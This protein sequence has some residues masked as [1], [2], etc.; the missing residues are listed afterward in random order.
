MNNVT[1]EL[2]SSRDQIIA[3]EN[4]R[5]FFDVIEATTINESHLHQLQEKIN[6]ACT[7]H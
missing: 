2:T 3:V 7:F 5:N 6:Q 1:T 4:R